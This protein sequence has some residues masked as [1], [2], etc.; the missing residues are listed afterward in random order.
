MLSVRS[1]LEIHTRCGAHFQWLKCQLNIA[2]TCHCIPIWQVSWIHSKWTT[3]KNTLYIK[4][5]YNEMPSIP[6]GFSKDG[7]FRHQRG[8]YLYLRQQVSTHQWLTSSTKPLQKKCA[9][10]KQ[11]PSPKKLKSLR[12]VNR[13]NMKLCD[14]F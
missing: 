10:W 5:T 2:K 7:C 12:L 13:N 6:D 8:I 1:G 9:W 3:T 11:T 4:S 14:S